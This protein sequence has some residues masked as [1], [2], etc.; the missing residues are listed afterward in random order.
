LVAAAASVAGGA[1]AYALAAHGVNLPA[2]LTTER[3]HATVA[4]TVAERGAGAM[5]DQPLS[6]IPYKVFGAAAG[7]A[8]IGV[9]AFVAASVAARGV[10]M[11]L[12]GAL[13]GLLG[14]VLAR[15]RR[16]YTAAIAAFV[17]VFAVVLAAVIQSWR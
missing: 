17:T 15:W 5:A 9:V 13:T 7:R 16:Y 11:L 6:G 14:A 12:V 3:M 1:V 10:R 8:H 4:R 2:P